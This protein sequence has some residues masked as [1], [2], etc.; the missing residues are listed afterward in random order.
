M[1]NVNYKTS[2]RKMKTV[3]AFEKTRGS[4]LN[5][6]QWCCITACQWLFPCRMFRYPS[7]LWMKFWKRH[8]MHVL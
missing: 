3:V 2:G 7:G 1:L 4:S 5:I 8:P 6:G